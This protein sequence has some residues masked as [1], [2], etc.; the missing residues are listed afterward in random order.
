MAKSVIIISMLL[1]AKQSRFTDEYLVDF[2]GTQ[3]AMRAGYSRRAARQIATENLIKPAIRA[4]I[5]QKQAETAQRLQITRDD[6][7]RGLVS[8]VDLARGQGDPRSMIRACRE[9]GKMLG[10]YDGRPEEQGRGAEAE[11]ELVRRYELMTE[12]ELLEI[13]GD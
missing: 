3:A 6:V 8:A 9:I 5:Q 4:V 2:N 10:Y 1:T 13:V 12:A 11:A 7:I